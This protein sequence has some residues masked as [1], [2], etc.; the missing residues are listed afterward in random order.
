MTPQS[1][2]FVCLGNICRSPSA[3]AVMTKLAKNQHL[4]IKFDSAGTANYH[5]G[6]ACDVRAIKTGSLL[7]FDLSQLR[8]RQVQ[9]ADFY[10]F[11]VIFAM[12]NNNLA[13][14]HKLMPK[15]ATATI[16]LFDDFDKKEVAD[17]YYGDM[18]DFE[19]MYAHIIQTSERWLNAWQVRHD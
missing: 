2:L 4:N 18:T 14:L 15:D 7:G 17:P 6:E 3:E 1:I 11:D 5:T 8:A 10:E 16:M 19:Q 9:Q 13:N 12:D